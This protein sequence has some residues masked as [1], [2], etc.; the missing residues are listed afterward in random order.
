MGDLHTKFAGS[1]IF[2]YLP[3]R[4]NS[5]TIYLHMKLSFRITH[6]ISSPYP[7]RVRGTKWP[8]PWFHLVFDWS[9]LTRMEFKGMIILFKKSVYLI[10]YVDI[11]VLNVKMCIPRINLIY[12]TSSYVRYNPHKVEFGCETEFS[13]TD[14]LGS[15]VAFLGDFGIFHLR[16]HPIVLKTKPTEF[17]YFKTIWNTY[18]LQKMCQRWIGLNRS[19]GDFWVAEF[20]FRCLDLGRVAK[21]CQ[22]IDF[23]NFPMP[24][25]W[26]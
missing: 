9:N 26:K 3:Q 10:R 18:H 19:E 23:F 2:Y 21:H 8:C 13:G 16:L 5:F 25:W 12:K 24:L 17:F 7:L 6:T 15:R 11:F 22:K 14:N 20:R 4:L 1:Q